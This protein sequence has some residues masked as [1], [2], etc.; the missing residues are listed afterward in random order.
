M[1]DFTVDPEGLRPVASLYVSQASD[2]DEIRQTLA[3]SDVGPGGQTSARIYVPP[4]G[5][6][7][8][9]LQVSASGHDSTATGFSRWAQNL[10][11]SSYATQAHLPSRLGS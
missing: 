6:L 10:A 8:D 5:A 7:L 11:S 2:M 3:T 1:T 9:Q 4:V